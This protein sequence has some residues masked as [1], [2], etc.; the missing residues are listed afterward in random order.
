M[1]S[2]GA[3]DAGR[4]QPCV[5]TVIALSPMVISLGGLTPGGSEEEAVQ[6]G[7]PAGDQEPLQKQSHHRHSPAALFCRGLTVRGRRPELTPVLPRLSCVHPTRVILNDTQHP[8]VS[9]ASIQT[10]LYLVNPLPPSV[11]SSLMLSSCPRPRPLPEEGPA[12]AGW[13]REGGS[14]GPRSAGG[15][16]KCM[17]PLPSRAS[18]SCLLSQGSRSPSSPGNTQ[19]H[20]GVKRRR[21]SRALTMR[22]AAPQ[23]P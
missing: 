11:D 12:A 18:P 16:L 9:P 10:A 17:L 7:V 23:V 2:E 19:V 14:W 5:C 6:L 22:R 21:N 8:R 13:G 1:R 20:K 3:A 15:S 4:A